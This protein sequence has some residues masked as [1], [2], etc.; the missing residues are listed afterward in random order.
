MV[1]LPTP[2]IEVTNLVVA[3]EVLIWLS[4]KQGSEEDVLNLRHTKDLIGDYVNAGSTIYL[5]R[6]LDRLR[7][8]AIY[9]DTDLVI[10]IQLN[11]E[12]ELI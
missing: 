6:Y 12:T 7:E 8:N 9:C 2:G 11:D 10:C 5:Y 3:R 4:W 1:F